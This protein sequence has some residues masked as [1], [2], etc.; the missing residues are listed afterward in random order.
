MDDYHFFGDEIFQKDPYS[1][2]KFVERRAILEEL[3][4]W[5]ADPTAHPA[6]KLISAPPGY[7]KTWLMNALSDRLAKLPD[8]FV[9]FYS[10]LKLTHP[11]A[12]RQ[13]LN[14]V[15]QQACTHCPRLEAPTPD[16]SIAGFLARLMA[17]LETDPALRP[18]FLLDGLDEPSP[19]EQSM[20]EKQLLEPTL[21]YPPARLVGSCRDDFGFKSLKLRKAGKDSLRLQPFTPA[22]AR[23]QLQKRPEL[24]H[25]DLPFDQDKLATL[26]TPYK[27]DVPYLTTTLVRLAKCNLDENREKLLSAD[28]IR[29]CWLAAIGVKFDQPTVSPGDLENNLKAMSTLAGWSGEDFAQ[30]CQLNMHQTSYRIGILMTLG[31]VQY[32]AAGQQYQVVNG[33]R[34]LIQAELRRREREEL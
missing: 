7:G 23:Q 25:G 28:D 10:A 6:L 31:V 33:L 30:Q 9:I 20:L 29:R 22:E 3:V 14:N 2:E 11:D 15:W 19:N 21:A 13:W 4:S 8:L 5:A 26:V 18:I 24:S 17:C 34:E 27:F 12:I 16:E 1:P 32:T